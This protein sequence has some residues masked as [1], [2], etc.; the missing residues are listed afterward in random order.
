MQPFDQF[1]VDPMHIHLNAILGFSILGNSFVMTRVA[2]RHNK[3]VAIGTVK[4]DVKRE[5]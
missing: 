2:E 5:R 1:K 3:S 4:I